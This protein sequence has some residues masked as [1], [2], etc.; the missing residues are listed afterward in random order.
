M[1]AEKRRQSQ[2]VDQDEK[3]KYRAASTGSTSH[4]R[5]VGNLAGAPG[6]EPGNGGIK[7]RSP[8]PWLRRFERHVQPKDRVLPSVL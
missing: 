5:R 1:L 2:A 7:I 6:F 4:A 8:E 3:L